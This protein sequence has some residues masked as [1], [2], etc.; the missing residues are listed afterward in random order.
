[1]INS[2]PMRII[3]NLAYAGFSLLMASLSCTQS[4]PRKHVFYLHGMIVQVQGIN[5]VS[6]TFGA[7]RYAEHS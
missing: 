2:M 7:Y 1:M 6:E 5:A 4:Q 3:Q